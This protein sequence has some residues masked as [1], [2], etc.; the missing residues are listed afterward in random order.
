M[1]FPEEHS[2]P[3]P[4]ARLTDTTRSKQ[5][6]INAG[7]ATHL[8]DEVLNADDVVLAEHLLDDGVVGERD[9]LLVDLAVAAL[10]DQLSDRFEVRVAAAERNHER[11]LFNHGEQMRSQFVTR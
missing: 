5:I 6:T 9:A 11:S 2:A 8:V 4:A 7:R 1:N 3:Q 10:V